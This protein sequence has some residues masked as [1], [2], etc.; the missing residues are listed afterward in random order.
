MI[1]KAE[2]KSMGKTSIIFTGDIGF[3]KYMDGRW[4]DERLFSKE[5]LSFFSSA[6]HT[7]ANIEGAVIDPESAA[8][9]LPKG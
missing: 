4:A 6:D 5:L 1:L 7:V 9:K 3:D 8:L 2:K